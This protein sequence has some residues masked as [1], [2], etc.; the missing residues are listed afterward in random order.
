VSPLAFPPA[1]LAALEG[2][3]E[4]EIETRAAPDGPLHSTI[5]WVVS[6]GPDVFIRSVNGGTARWYREARDNRVEVKLADRRLPA[7]AV[8]AVDETSVARTSAAFTRKY[9]AYSDMPSMVEDDILDTTLRLE[10][11]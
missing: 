11:A 3:Y 7:R 2:A 1:E 9:A 6:D 8:P 5:I 10:P 4:I